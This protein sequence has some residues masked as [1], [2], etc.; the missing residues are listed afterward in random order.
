M[1]A[2]FVQYPLLFLLDPKKMP[3]GLISHYAPVR[4]ML[5]VID[6]TGLADAAVHT[7]AGGTTLVVVW[8][9]LIVVGSGA[10][11]ARAEVR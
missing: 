3:F 8:L 1:T 9:V 7:L 2:F 4:G 10:V 5:V 11:F 6:P